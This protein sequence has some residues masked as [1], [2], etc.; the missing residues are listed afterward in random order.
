MFSSSI[1]HLDPNEW[2]DIFA[3]AGAKYVDT[4]SSLNIIYLLVLYVDTS[5]SRAKFVQT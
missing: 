5:F 4:V 3:A 2:A 1:L